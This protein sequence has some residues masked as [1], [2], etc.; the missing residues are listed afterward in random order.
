[1]YMGVKGGKE[2]LVALHEQAVALA[3]V[4]KDWNGE[5]GALSL[6]NTETEFNPSL[7]KEL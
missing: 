5:F 7:A 3:E 2:E 6:G 4:L 1:M